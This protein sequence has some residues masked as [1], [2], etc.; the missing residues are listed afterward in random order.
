ML[1]NKPFRQHLPCMW[2]SPMAD[3]FRFLS[4]FVVWSLFP[5][6]AFGQQDSCINLL[7]SVR[8]NSVAS[9]S[10][11]NEIERELGNGI[12]L[13][14][15]EE[16]SVKLNQFQQIILNPTSYQKAAVILAH[17]IGS[18]EIGRD[19]SPAR[20]GNYTNSQILRKS[21][22][23]FAA[24][25][26]RLE[27]REVIEQ[28]IAG[29]GTV[30]ATV[31]G[32]L[33]GGP[34]GAVAGYG[35]AK[36]YKGGVANPNAIMTGALVG[37]ALDAVV[38]DDSVLDGA[39][40]GA[41]AGQAI[42]E[43][44]AQSSVQGQTVQSGKSSSVQGQAVQS[45]MSRQVNVTY[46]FDHSLKDEASFY[47]DALRDVAKL[48]GQSS[49]QGQAV[50]SVTSSSINA[51]SS[52]D[53]DIPTAVGHC[54]GTNMAASSNAPNTIRRSIYGLC[55]AAVIGIAT[56]IFLN[57]HHG[58]AAEQENRIRIETQGSNSPK[59]GSLRESRSERSYLHQP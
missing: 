54:V 24:G 23:L 51:S 57:D 58:S 2:G 46:S 6:V 15:S 32:F 11:Q 3:F 47:E 59:S 14:V 9:T 56:M 55:T 19:G 35:L 26:G 49:V 20:T 38:G 40:L 53:R 13:N 43:L 37:G 22:Y 45:G 5:A 31:G 27:R 1:K 29:V 52:N 30:V 21:R 10:F 4:H 33:V 36:S 39:L 25:I 34:F 28:G 7:G 12:L 44:N 16:E 18:H 50:Q 17:R 42:A 41:A 8:V 48:T